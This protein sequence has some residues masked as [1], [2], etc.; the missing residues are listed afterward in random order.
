MNVLQEKKQI[1]E[2]MR[3]LRRSLFEAEKISGSKRIC[4]FLIADLVGRKKGKLFAYLALR[5]EPNLEAALE[6]AQ[7]LG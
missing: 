3:D 1:R 7:Q 2:Q 6:M 5:E 4:D